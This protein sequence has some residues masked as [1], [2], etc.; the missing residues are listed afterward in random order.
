MSLSA[1]VLVDAI[2]LIS[3]H[4]IS[5]YL[6]IISLIGITEIREHASGIFG[7]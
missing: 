3:N 4:T 1:F 6:P 7:A 5:E 2:L